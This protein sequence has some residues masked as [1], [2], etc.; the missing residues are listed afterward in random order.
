VHDDVEL[1]AGTE[2]VL[3]EEPR[4]IRLFDG[5]GAVG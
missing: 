2:D 1:V 5:V 4:G 3:A